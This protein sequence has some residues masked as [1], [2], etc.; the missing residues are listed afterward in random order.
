MYPVPSQLSLKWPPHIQSTHNIYTVQW[1]L[2]FWRSRS[3]CNQCQCQG[4][5]NISKQNKV[6]VSLARHRV[7]PSVP[8]IGR[9]RSSSPISPRSR[10]ASKVTLHQA[11]WP[12]LLNDLQLVLICYCTPF[13]WMIGPLNTPRRSGREAGAEI[14]SSRNIDVP[15]FRSRFSRRAKHA[16]RC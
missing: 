10:S 15:L 16:Q 12:L 9:S 3:T 4:H 11:V 7:F 14:L 2:Q 13:Y 1:P 6:T 8:L 5:C